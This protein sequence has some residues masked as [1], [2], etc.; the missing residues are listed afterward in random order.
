MRTSTRNQVAAAVCLAAFF[1]VD[2]IAGQ[3]GCAPAPS[4]LVGWWAGEGNALDSTGVN[5][6]V[7]EGNMAFVPGEVGLAF[8]L[9]GTTADVRV[10]ASTSVDV[11]AGNGM[12][13]ELW[14][15]PENVLTNQ[16][17]VE[18]NNGY[19]GVL[20]DLAVPVSVGGAGPGSFCGY[21]KDVTYA[22]H[23]VNSPAGALAA[24]TFQHVAVTYDKG[25]GIG[26]AY[27][28]GVMVDQANLGVFRPMTLGDVYFGLRPSDAGAGTRYAGLM[29]EVSLYD[30]ALSAAEIQAI[31]AA[32]SGGKCQLPPVIVVQPRSQTATPGAT[33]TFN[34]TAGGSPPLSYHW[35]LNSAN[36]AGATNSSLALTNVQFANAGV[37]RVVVSNSLG[38]VTSSPAVLTV[39]YPPA[40]VEA[41]NASGL[42]SRA[43]TV[44]IL[45]VANGNE[46]ALTFTLDFDRGQL[47]Y[48]S[49]VLGAGASKGTLILNPAGAA[50]GL[51]GLGVALPA[52][53][54]F[55]TGTQVVANVTFTLALI[56]N[57]TFATVGFSNQVM[58]SQVVDA[59]A[60]PLPATFAG[61]VVTI[62]PTP[63]AGDVWPRPNGDEAVTVSDW[64]LEGRYVAKLDYPTNAGEFERA[65]CAPRATGGDN[66]ITVADW[67]QVGRY[68]AGLDPVTPAGT[69]HGPFGVH[70]DIRAQ[71]D[72]PAAPLDNDQPRQVRV[73]NAVIL[74]GEAGTVAV[75]L[76]ALGDENAVA[77]SLAFDPSALA[78]NGASSGS[79][80]NGASFNLNDAQAADGQLGFAL[81]LEPGATF[82]SGGQQLATIG[83][84]AWPSASGSYPLVLTSLPV[85][86][87]VSDANAAA[88][89][90]VSYI[91]GSVLIPPPPSLSIALSGQAIR[92]S[93]PLW[94]T[95]FVLERASGQLSP[96]RN[97]SSLGT[98]PGVTANANV[99]TLPLSATNTFYR[100]RQR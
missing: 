23:P 46:N 22:G 97:W 36:L 39:T 10:P 49:A 90:N 77:F 13:I 52:G 31:Y 93:W 5:D 57:T 2:S 12:T 28:N 72:P 26:A 71:Q 62:T 1:I 82:P 53:A 64:V 85:A 91:N 48:K 54:V 45:L 59:H 69:N 100:L 56:T 76:E 29:D 37:Y 89:T 17:V 43:V 24:N 86:R 27:L 3:T 14:L 30:R 21:F 80:A 15:K 61:G 55:K 47:S 44:P 99:F 7:L 88:Q 51:V 42:G 92:L 19:F 6:G 58:R 9:D 8:S 33:V 11:G 63:I 78:Y 16:S 74:P 35:Q 41:A 67:V 38:S 40:L 70:P 79:G 96:G 50:N 98:A 95:N 18:W 25:S 83:F 68:L 75:V 60:N 87:E 81:A 4:G 66:A 20:L 34:A 84:S 73:Q 65:D 94:A 32:G